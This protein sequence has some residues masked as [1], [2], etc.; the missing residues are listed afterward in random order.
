MK[1]ETFLKSTGQGVKENPWL[2][3]VKC[4]TSVDSHTYPFLLTRHPM[5]V[6]ASLHLSCSP[7]PSRLPHMLLSL[8][9]VSQTHPSTAVPGALR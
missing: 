5:I 7:L 8:P 6:I 2:I 4:F 9:E 3:D 1:G